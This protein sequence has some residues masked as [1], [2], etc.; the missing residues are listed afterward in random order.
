MSA[1]EAPLFRR[2]ALSEASEPDR[3]DEPLR[4]MR[5][6]S[7]VVGACLLAMVVLGLGWAALVDVPVKVSGRGIL[8]ASGGVIDIVAD[9]DGRIETLL[10]RP[11][12]RIAAGQPVAVVDQ[13]EVRL[14]LA[15]AEG[16]AA[17]ATRQRQELVAFHRREE[18]AADAFRVAREA[19]LEQNLVLLQDR[20]GMMQQREEVLRTLSQ[21]NLVNRDRFLFARVEVFQVREQIAA[22][23]NE[24]EQLALDQALKRTQRERET[25]EVER[26]VD[27]TSRQAQAL[28]ERLARLGSVLAPVG[29]RVV[30]VKVNAGQVVTRGTPLLTIEREPAGGRAAPVAILYVTAQDGKRLSEGMAVEVS[31]SSTRREEHG[32]VHGRITRV[33]ET[34]ASSAG[35]LRTL[36]ND[37]LVR[38][39]STAFGTPLEV[40]V[41]LDTDPATRSGLRW[42]T[43]RGPDFAI[44]PGTLTDAE[45]TVRSV[46]L[47]GLAFPALRGALTRNADPA[48]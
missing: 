41:T 48:P 24:R 39:F 27:E 23:R 2:E 7:W 43:G 13:S 15:L 5:P 46:K 10:A 6:W 14:Q 25:L 34:P 21:Q 17:D 44:E 28:R 3:Y 22:A 30:E 31:P 45:V 47:L 18:S 16:Q 40:E 36:Q 12:E 1:S 20:L 26:R 4:V 37:Q 8:L 11:G 33:A 35:L 32:F 29:G 42:S 38:S 9:T 19:A